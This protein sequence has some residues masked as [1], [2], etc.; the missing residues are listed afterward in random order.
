MGN[1]KGSKK[2]HL[3]DI[4]VPIR[5]RSGSTNTSKRGFEQDFAALTKFKPN[6][7]YEGKLILKVDFYFTGEY[8]GDIDN[9]LKS[10]FDALERDGYFKDDWQ[11]KE[12]G[13]KI[14]EYALIEGIGIRIVGPRH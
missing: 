1:K 3:V 14:H 7:P 5:G 9:L 6:K 4:F 8:L 13:A 12:V 10:L 11:I 2:E